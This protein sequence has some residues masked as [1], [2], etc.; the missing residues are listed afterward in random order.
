MIRRL[1]N[2][3]KDHIVKYVA[4]SGGDYT[5]TAAALA[6]ITDAAAGKRYVIL[7]DNPNE[8]IDTQLTWKQYVSLVGFGRSRSKVSGAVSQ[9][10]LTVP[11]DCD[12][13]GMTLQNTNTGNSWV[14]GGVKGAVNIRDC[15]L[16]SN[17]A[18][19]IYVNAA[20]ST[21][22][23]ENSYLSGK[24]DILVSQA[25]DSVRTYMRN[26]DVFTDAGEDAKILRI[27]TGDILERVRVVAQLP[28]GAESVVGVQGAGT[29]YGCSVD[30][31][32]ANINPVYGIEANGGTLTVIDTTVRTAHEDRYE[33]RFDLRVSG[34][35]V[36]NVSN[37]QYDDTKVD[38][39]PVQI[40][41][42]PW[43][44]HGR[45]TMTSAQLGRMLYNQWRRQA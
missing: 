12:I 36:M 45:L 40:D 37:C 8:V 29:L 31:A 5:T 41:R 22:T 39:T 23:V 30:L 24:F 3:Y 42:T 26:V 11:W 33:T 43:Q 35:G 38:G 10:L 6:A 28:A 14:V 16:I 2:P 34:S 27:V 19:N 44:A 32:L 1:V 21:L 13:H 20:S 4:P 25:G 17:G 9:A 15:A 7:H 18:D